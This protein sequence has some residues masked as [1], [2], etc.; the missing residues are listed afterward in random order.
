M[1]DLIRG[2][3]RD[4]VSCLEMVT[5]SVVAPRGLDDDLGSRYQ[6]E[7]FDTLSR[8][9]TYPLTHDAFA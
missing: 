9:A 8:A 4:T 5:I 6:G 2:A 7:G 3:Y 1:V